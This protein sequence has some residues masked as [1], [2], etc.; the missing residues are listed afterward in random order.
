MKFTEGVFSFP[1][2]V[3]DTFSVIKNVKEESERFDELDAPLPDDWVE[4]RMKWPITD[5]RGWK[6]DFSSDRKTGDVA[7]EGFDLTI[8][9]THSGHG[10][11]ECLWTMD[12]LEKEL[13]AFAEKYEKGIEKIVTDAFKEKEFEAEQRKATVKKK[14]RW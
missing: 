8:I 12:R 14:W 6:D 9:F 4:G 10:P 5:I 2:K 3:Y 7:K 11:F 1:T 13:D